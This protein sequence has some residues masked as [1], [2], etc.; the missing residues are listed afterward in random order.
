MADQEE[1]P[2]VPEKDQP[3]P[4]PALRGTGDGEE[5]KR[6][7]NAVLILIAVMFII[8]MILVVAGWGNVLKQLEDEHIARGLITFVVTLGVVSIAIITVLAALMGR[9]GPE[10]KEKFARAKEILTIL[11]GILGTIVGFYFGQATADES[12]RQPPKPPPVTPP[13]DAES[14]GEEQP[15]QAPAEDDQTQ[16]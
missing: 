5:Q 2:P 12:P 1:K 6:E 15:D 9:G 14:G 7:F 3:Q 16:E 13:A 10:A 11:V 4:E 8:P